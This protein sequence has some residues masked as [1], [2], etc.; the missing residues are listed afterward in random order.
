MTETRRFCMLTDTHLQES[1]AK[2]LVQTLNKLF[3]KHLKG[4]Q[5]WEDH[6]ENHWL[7]E[8]IF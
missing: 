2:E 5:G 8:D 1:V 6:A 4:S 7:P 3:A